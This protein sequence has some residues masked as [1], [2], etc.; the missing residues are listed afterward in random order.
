MIIAVETVHGLLRAIWLVPLVGDLRSRQI[1][2]FTGSLLIL[3]ITWV[4]FGWLR[5]ES[6]RTLVAV[7]LLWV[8]LTVL[9]EVV[10]GRFV[11]GYQWG[12][13]LADYD[14]AHGGLM[15]FGL[16]L[17]ASAPLIAHA[18]LTRRGFAL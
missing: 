10:L 11:M 15:G 17:M 3:A 2:V 7:G 16:L 5:P 9:F 12:R 8:V 14:L 13:L 1:G 18:V 4:F 6:R